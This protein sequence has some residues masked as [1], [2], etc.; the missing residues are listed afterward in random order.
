MTRN[1]QW[2][3]VAFVIGLSLGVVGV[4]DAMATTVNH[5]FLSESR[6]TVL[7]ATD[8]PRTNHLLTV[9]PFAAV[10]CETSHFDGVV[11]GTTVDLV[12]V[13]PSYTDCEF[14]G[15]PATVDTTG[16]GYILE[17]DTIDGHADVYIECSSTTGIEVE[18]DACTITIGTQT[19]KPG[20]TY[21]NVANGDVTVKATV[22]D[23]EIHSWE[24]PLCELLVTE[25]TITAEYEG[26]ALVEGF[27]EGGAPTNI[28]IGGT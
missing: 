3:G 10:E 27:T 24:G 20:V 26:V 15:T 28:A 14:F 9:G 23:I 16:C 6:R 11:V 13:H 5:E 19:T 8:E 4:Q 17:S 12:T 22:P 7:K 18:T 25:G 21:T 2:L 1:I